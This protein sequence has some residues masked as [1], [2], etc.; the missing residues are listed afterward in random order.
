VP[1]TAPHDRPTAAELVEAVR[2]FLADDVAP[3]LEGR[4]A[5][6]LRIALNVLAMVERELDVGPTQA[7]AHAARLAALGVTDDRELAAA[8]RA[9]R[10][11]DRWDEV[12]AAVRAAVVDKLAVAHPGYTRPDSA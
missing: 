11:D 6:Q 4:D 3:R 12:V 2:E 1:V 5:F 9:G 7:A 8:V 10:L